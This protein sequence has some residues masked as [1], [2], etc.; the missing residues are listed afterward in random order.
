MN[1]IQTCTKAAVIALI[2][3]SGPAAQPVTPAQPT[4]R[5]SPDL[6]QVDVIA[7]TAS[8]HVGGLGP[9]DFEIREDGKPR[10][11]TR[12]AFVNAAPPAQ[13]IIAFLA[14]NCDSAR[15]G[16]F[17]FYSLPVVLAGFVRDR[18]QPNDMVSI[19]GTVEGSGRLQRPGN[20]RQGLLQAIDGLGIFGRTVRICGDAADMHRESARLLG[21]SPGSSWNGQPYFN[22]PAS[23]NAINA[24]I[25]GLAEMPGRKILIVV[26]RFAGWV[27]YPEKSQALMRLAGRANRAGV[28]IYVLDPGEQQDVKVDRNPRELSDAYERLKNLRQGGGE[29]LARATGGFY[30]YNNYASNKSSTPIPGRMGRG[31]SPQSRD[32]DEHAAEFVTN[33]IEEILADMSSYYLIGYDPER[34]GPADPSAFHK[35]EVRVK[36]RRV[37]ARSRAGYYENP[38]NSEAPSG[39]GSS[40]G[41]ALRSPFRGD[42]SM[43][44]LPYYPAFADASNDPSRG[45]LRAIAAIDPRDLRFEPQADGTVK[46]SVELLASVFGSTGEAAAYR[47]GSCAMSITPAEMNG[48]GS[49][50]LLCNL[51]LEIH[52]AGAYMVRVAALE[53]ATGKTGSAYALAG[54]PVFQRDQIRLSTL[55]LSPP[56]PERGAPAAPALTGANEVERTF[57]PGASL[58]YACDVFG[59]ALAREEGRARLEAR[60]MLN[61]PKL[62]LFSDS[63]LLPVRPEYGP[64]MHITGK[65]TLPPDLAPGHYAITLVVYDQMRQP[66]QA[67]EQIMDFEVVKPEAPA[68]AR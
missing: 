64:R 22:G 54:V 46:A 15:G 28:A 30:Y 60:I 2:A 67:A 55:T 56:P 17:Q 37:N 29:Y 20:N 33:R 47:S 57:A 44:I 51:D 13:R 52:E 49:R 45:F 40:L 42:I 7:E 23:F 14:D 59:A 32:F 58:S 24:A 11:I 35:I 21:Q 6:V 1:S 53:R 61:A 36:R 12:F 48:I 9:E 10:K 8:V 27:Q 26:S 66:P 25:D 68:P 65:L 5:F 16:S 19:L 31:P 3:A 39:G 4:I 38:A 50:R 63:G 34:A 18:M 62:F 43:R 41:A